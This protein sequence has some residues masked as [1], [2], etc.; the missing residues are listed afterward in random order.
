MKFPPFLPSSLVALL[1]ASCSPPESEKASVQTFPVRGVVQQRMGDD[2]A[3]M[4]IDHEEI[5]G[6]M[7][8]MIMPFRALDPAE[9]ATLE[10]GMVV[11]FDYHVEEHES[12]V[13]GV[14]VTGEKG[15]ITLEEEPAAGDEL[16]S[17]GDEFPDFTFQDE[18]GKTVKLSDFR[19]MPVAISFVFS[20]CPVPEYCPRMMSQFSSL[21]AALTADPKAPER[22]HLLTI[23]FDHEFDSPEIMKSWGASFGHREGMP[24]SLLSTTEGEVID[25]IASRVGL[26]YGVVNG[27]IQHNLRTIVLN[28]DGTMRRL[29]LDENWTV[30][31]ILGEI[32][33]AAGSQDA[34]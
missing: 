16:V 8:R 17:A 12:W 23:S 31:E 4:I 13:T 26:R 10:P 3:M 22:Y 29:F 32:V 5:P 19:G 28:P 21:I 33:A 1:L 15:A 25:R 11:T 20:R 34:L 27:T 30:P 9:F 7:P 14:K 18:N 2:P 6:F 24:W